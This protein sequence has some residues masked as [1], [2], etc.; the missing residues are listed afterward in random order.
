MCG[1]LPATRLSEAGFH[2][3]ALM[4]STV[5]ERQAAF[6]RFKYVTLLLGGDEAGKL[7]FLYFLC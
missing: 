1:S 3:I 2:C 5:S 4:G 6:L 7:Y